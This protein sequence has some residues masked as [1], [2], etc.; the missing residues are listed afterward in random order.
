MYS[1]FRGNVSC[2]LGTYYTPADEKVKVVYCKKTFFWGARC[3]A[4]IFVP[5]LDRWL[6]C[7]SLV[8]H[9]RNAPF[10][11]RWLNCASLVCHAFSGSVA[12]LRFACLPL[13]ERA[14]TPARESDRTGRTGRTGRT[15]PN[16]AKT[17]ISGAI[18]PRLFW[19]GLFS[20]AVARAQHFAVFIGPIRLISPM[21]ARC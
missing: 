11:D 21:K 3:L 1:L 9:W 7:A 12:Q 19:I 17:Q 13:A 18:L 16:L 2:F 14:A 15:R 20:F 4:W 8:C 5:F 10:L 6:N